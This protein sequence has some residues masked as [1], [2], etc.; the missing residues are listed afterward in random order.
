MGVL[1]IYCVGWGN[2]VNMLLC[3]SAN[4]ARANARI[5]ILNGVKKETNALKRVFWLEHERRTN[6]GHAEER[7]AS[8]ASRTMEKQPLTSSFERVASN[9]MH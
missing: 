1:P 2:F 7:P 4:F 5:K 9:N 6:V 3:T 8:A